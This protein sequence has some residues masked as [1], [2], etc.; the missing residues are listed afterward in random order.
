MTEG[1]LGADVID[2]PVGRTRMDPEQIDNVLFAPR[3]RW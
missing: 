1:E 2:A 3:G